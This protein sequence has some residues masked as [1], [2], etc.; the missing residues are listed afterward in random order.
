MNSAFTGHSSEWKPVPVTFA[1]CVASDPS[2]NTHGAQQDL[3]SAVIAA[4]AEARW[5]HN[6]TEEDVFTAAH[7]PIKDPSTQLLIYAQRRPQMI[8][9]PLL[10]MEDNEAA[11]KILLKGRSNAVRHLHRTHRINIDDGRVWKTQF[12]NARCAFGIGG[13]LRG[14]H[15]KGRHD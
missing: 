11:I 2:V 13:C 9:V 12:C 7:I 4:N 3:W 5:G 10:V 14:V 8:R 1:G 15:G 6:Y